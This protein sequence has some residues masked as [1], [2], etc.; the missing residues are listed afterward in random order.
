MPGHGAKQHPQYAREPPVDSESMEVSMKRWL[1]IGTVALTL[2]LLLGFVVLALRGLI[3]P[4]QASGRFGTAVSDPA[5]ALFYRVYLS[6]NLVIVLTGAVF[7]L[8]GQW[9]ALAILFS[10]T[11]ALPVFDM[12]VLSLNGVTPPAF[13]PVALV[14]LAVTALLL[15]RRALIGG[16]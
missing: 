2:L 1:D 13:H 15:W 8:L 3:D 14:L 12:S 7:L 4:Q 6:R 9:R 10:V 11:A 16:R 5:G